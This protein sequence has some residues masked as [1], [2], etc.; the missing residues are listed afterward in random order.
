MKEKPNFDFRM[1]YVSAYKW[2][3]LSPSPYNGNE[4]WLL[5]GFFRTKRQ[6]ELFVRQGGFDIFV[7]GKWT[8][9]RRSQ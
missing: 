1:G 3:V 8:S 5:A 4:A 7:I 2:A 9:T 6:A